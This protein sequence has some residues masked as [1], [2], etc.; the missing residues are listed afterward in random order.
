MIVASIPR[1]SLSQH[2]GRGASQT[3]KALLKARTSD[4]KIAWSK[5]RNLLQFHCAYSTCKKI[6]ITAKPEVGRVLE[7]Q[8]KQPR[9]LRQGCSPPRLP[10][11]VGGLLT[12]LIGKDERGATGLDHSLL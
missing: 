3:S 7:D 2:C 10:L 1:P 9:I 5:T 11:C 12:I 6:F 8:S 4:F